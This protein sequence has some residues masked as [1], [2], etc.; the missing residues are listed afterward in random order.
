MKDFIFPFRLIRLLSDGAIH[1][2]KAL[3]QHLGIS[4]PD[5]HQ[6][7][8]ALRHWGLDIRLQSDK[9]YYL[10]SPIELLDEKKIW[11]DLPEGRI[12][13]LTLVNSTNQY[14]LDQIDALH[15][16]DACVAEHQTAGRG[17]RGRQWASPFGQ[18]LYLSMFWRFKRGVAA[19]VGLS[20]AIGVVITEVLHHLGGKAIRV[21]WPNDLYHRDKKL[22]G[23]LVELTGKTAEPAQVVIGMGINLNRPLSDNR[24]DQDWSHLKEAGITIDRNKL[25]AL[26]L[27]ELRGQMMIFEDEGLSAFISRWHKLDNYLDRPV[28]LIMEDQ[29]ISGIARGIDQQGALLLETEKGIKAYPAGEMSL[30]GK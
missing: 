26:L 30:R 28:R 2:G 15:S 13:V 1:S 8:E 14:L 12:T 23:I 17:R 10:L 27:S 9:G 20:L 3:A 21:K 7:L 16:G 5:V 19:S 29:E 11:R 4:V 24:I 25:T 18:N 22:A 6:H